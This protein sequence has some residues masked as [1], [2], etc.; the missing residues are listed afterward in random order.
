MKVTSVLVATLLLASSLGFVMVHADEPGHA[1]SSQTVTFSFFQPSIEAGAEYVRVHIPETHTYHLRPGYPTLPIRS[2]TLT[3]PMGTTVTDV[4]VTVGAVRTQTLQQHVSPAPEP[5]PLDMSLTLK[6]QREGDI[7][8][9]NTLYP[10]QWARWHTGGGIMDGRHVQF[11]S[12]QAFP[13]R[14]APQSRE[15][16]YAENINIT[17]HYEASAAGLLNPDT[18]DLLIISPG[19]YVDALQPLVVHKE[20]R[21]LST[22]LVTLAEIEAGAYFEPQGRDE[23]ET[24]KYFI[25]DAVEEWGV[26]Y[27]MLVGGDDAIPVRYVAVDDGEES[28]YISDLYYA[29]IYDA[30]GAFVD[31]D[32]NDNNLFGEFTE[33][34]IDKVDLY[35]DVYLGRLACQNIVE[36]KTVVEK[37]ISYEN[38]PAYQMAWFKEIVY[39]GGDTFPGDENAINEGEYANQAI[40]DAMDGFNARKL[41]ASNYKIDSTAKITEAVSQGAGFVDFSGHGSS[42]SWATHPHE[43]E[44][45]WLPTG[46]YKTNDVSHLHNEDAWPI[47]ILNACSNAKFSTACLGWSFVGQQDSGAIAVCGNTALGYGYFGSYVTQGLSGFMELHSFLS[48]KDGAET[49]G[50]LWVDTLHSYINRYGSGMG[51]HDYKSIEEWEPLGDPSLSIALQTTENAA[52]YK[53]DCLVGPTSGERWH[54]YTYQARTTDPDGDKLYYKFDWGDGTNTSWL[55]PY[56]SNTTVNAT[57]SW[58][59]RGEYEIKV[60]AKDSEGAESAWSDPL[61]ISMP[62]VYHLRSLLHLLLTSI[63][64]DDFIAFWLGSV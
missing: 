37:I 64:I 59:S 38:M 13:V 22:M 42:T 53:P 30:D 24:V 32:S 27:V 55:G 60:K 1:T 40:I 36:V 14:Y 33:T 21:N 3:L 5:T 18:Y 35:P 10:E 23:A 51:L 54:E 4:N 7:Y 56:P 45:R 12:I 25:K 11:L 57:H 46:G 17:I 44:N 29:D 2:Q 50:E 41:W 61:P 48:Y 15:I 43:R 16:H 52:P 63:S 19:E 58:E 8:S 28:R 6:E 49:F 20:A 34:E 26:E 39:C 62:L 31:W 47:I 9:S